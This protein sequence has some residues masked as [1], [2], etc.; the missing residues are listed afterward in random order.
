MARR[1]KTNAGAV[2]DGVLYEQLSL[3]LRDQPAERIPTIILAYEPRW[4]IGASAAASPD[5]AA[6]RH[7]GLRK[8]VSD[9]FGADV[10]AHVRIIYGGSVTPSNGEALMEHAD[11]DGLFVGRAAWSAEGFADI[12]AI[13]ARAAIRRENSM[14]IVLAADSAGKP[15][16]DVIA[17]HLA[18]KAELEVTDLSQPGYYADIADRAASA[19]AK[20]EYERGIL[21]CG[22]GIGMS[23]FGQQGPGHQSGFDPRH[24]FGGTRRQIE[25]R[26]D[27][28]NGRQGD[29][30]RTC[31]GH[32]RH[33]ARFGF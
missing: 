10:A 2:A 9:R 20:G 24:L 23:H 1:P 16:L 29:R 19:V 5:Y 6:E 3:A 11:I 25:Q 27:H 33:L 18:G 4:A 21:F 28:H 31:Q 30:T 32:R 7:R 12:A 17:A 14:K 15:L 8:A 26:T 22:T 13:V